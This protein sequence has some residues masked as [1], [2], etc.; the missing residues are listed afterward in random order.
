MSQLLIHGHWVEGE[1]VQVLKDKY[2]KVNYFI[3]IIP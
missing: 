2:P 1:S 3:H